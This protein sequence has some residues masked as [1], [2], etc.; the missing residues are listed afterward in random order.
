ME[1]TQE[2]WVQALGQED[3]LEKGMATHPSILVCKIHGQRS[4]VGYSPR[5]HKESALTEQLIWETKILYTGKD[6]TLMKEIKDDINRWEDILSSWIG[7]TNIVNITILPKAIYR[8][9]VIP[10]TLK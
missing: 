1:E 5:G 6:K 4:P 3:P 7:I 10:I 9:N 2:T 8:F